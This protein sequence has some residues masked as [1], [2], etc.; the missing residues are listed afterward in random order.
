MY[1]LFKNF[2]ENVFHLREDIFFYFIKMRS[3]QKVYFKNCNPG[4]SARGYNHIA[5]I[6]FSH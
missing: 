5:N 1:Y 6:G 4:A 2:E 3:L